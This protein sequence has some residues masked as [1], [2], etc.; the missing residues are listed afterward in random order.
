MS[1]F[2]QGLFG[3]CAFTITIAVASKIN[4]DM[5]RKRLDACEET[6][7]NERKEIQGYHCWK[8]GGTHPFWPCECDD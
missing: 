5:N 6:V 8:T 3:L 2:F 1:S 7:K 4:P